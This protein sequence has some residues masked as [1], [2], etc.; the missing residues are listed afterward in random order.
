MS[1]SKVD[2]PQ[3]DAFGASSEGALGNFYDRFDTSG[4]LLTCDLRRRYQKSTAQG[5]PQE[6]AKSSN[7][8]QKKKEMRRLYN[9]R[10]KQGF[11][12]A[13]L[14]AS[15]QNGCSSCEVLRSVF[16]HVSLI[17]PNDYQSKTNASFNVSTNFILTKQYL[18]N[19]ALETQHIGLFNPLGSSVQFPAMPQA[20][21]LCG[22]TDSSLSMARAS[23][24]LKTCVDTHVACQ[25]K[26][27]SGPPSRLIDVTEIKRWNIEGVKLI[28]TSP[29]QVGK[30]TCLSHCWGKVPI[31]CCTTRETLQQAK[32]FIPYASMPQNFRDAVEIT[33][34]LQIQYIWIDSMCIL[35]G[36]RHDWE[37]ESAKMA[38]VYK[39]GYVTI[40]AAASADSTGGCFNKTDPDICLRITPDDGKPFL[41]GTRMCDTLGFLKDNESTQ[42]RYPLLQRGWVLQE[43]LLSRRTLYCNYGELAFRCLEDFSC[44]CGSTNMAPHANGSNVTQ[45]RIGANRLMNTAIP[46]R[47]TPIAEYWRDI[48][49]KYMRLN[50][51]ELSDLLP[52]ISGCARELSEVTGDE[53][54]AGFWKKTFVQSLLWYIK[55]TNAIAREGWTAPT[56]SWASVPPGQDINFC[57]KVNAGVIKQRLT[58]SIDRLPCNFGQIS[59]GTGS[60]KLK[61][62]LFPCYI[63]HFCHHSNR[64]IEAA[65]V[66]RNRRHFRLHQQKY[67]K[68]VDG[69]CKT[70]IP[71][72]S[73]ESGSFQLLPDIPLR[74]ALE[75]R[76]FP[77]CVGCS[78]AQIWLL[79][80]GEV[81]EGGTRQDYFIMLRVVDKEAKIYE[82]FGMT[83]FE[84]QPVDR[85]KSWFEDVWV[86]A[87]LPEEYIT[88][89]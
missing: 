44:E 39:N 38:D 35:Q 83:M 46:G 42:R 81:T 49:A 16:E 64:A 23:K 9:D 79:H 43:R 10:L 28:E 24:W 7:R 74:D 59:P 15:I 60:L 11:T 89:S 61:V 77:D 68:D 5:M 19:D 84:R 80:T 31:K 27:N 69:L 55:T 58:Y 71:G 72:V 66:T 54:F 76:L 85:R 14:L 30:Y 52:A 22:D 87:V 82:R 51:T 47:D 88:I 48:V 34:R 50:L 8:F 62:G 37:V 63:R 56:W 36:D 3:A 45:R 78:L 33:R 73:V 20:S 25:P 2:F 1:V 13:E 18:V 12:L 86:K 53:Y 26:I 41:I 32:E 29:G 6:D 70:P 40:A 65:G 57:E 4:C 17:K 75:Y 21:F 67:K